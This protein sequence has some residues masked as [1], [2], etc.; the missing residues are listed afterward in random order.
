MFRVGPGADAGSLVIEG[1]LDLA[2]IDRLVSA[3]DLCS[4]P[5]DELVIDCSRLTFVDG[6]GVQAFIDIAGRLPASTVLVL[7]G[8]SGFVLRV[9]RL[10]RI[11]SYPRIEVRP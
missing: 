7:A 4:V 11:D 8:A 6:T 3:V 1:E 5:E 9:L 2:S 10:L